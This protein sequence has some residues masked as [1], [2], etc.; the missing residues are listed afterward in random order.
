MI[1]P[2]LS[3]FR[4]RLVAE[5]SGSGGKPGS[6]DLESRPGS[7]DFEELGLQGFEVSVGARW[8]WTLMQVKGLMT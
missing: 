1:D 6:Q 8:L 3:I 2:G 5:E 7:W 4:C